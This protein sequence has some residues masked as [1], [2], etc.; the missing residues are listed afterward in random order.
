MEKCLK[1]YPITN[2]ETVIA[3]IMEKN[4]FDPKVRDFK[5]KF[6]GGATIVEIDSAGRLLLP[7]SLKEH[8]GLGKDI[9]LVSVG[10]KVEIW[11]SGKY[12]KFFEEFSAE[13]FSKLAAEVMAGQVDKLNS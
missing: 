7:P 12:K 5:R 10:N 6:L 8:A 4:D 2:W 1:M 3:S 11:E 13:D 9:M